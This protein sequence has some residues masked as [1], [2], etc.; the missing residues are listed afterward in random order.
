ML[1]LQKE[2]LRVKNEELQI[3]EN[4]YRMLVE[5]SPDAK[6]SAPETILLIAQTQTLTVASCT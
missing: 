1:Q 5:N 6:V 2:E 4:K 3:S